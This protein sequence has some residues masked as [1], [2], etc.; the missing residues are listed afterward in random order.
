MPNLWTNSESEEAEVMV[1][2]DEKPEGKPKAGREVN[3]ARKLEKGRKKLPPAK[4][5]TVKRGFG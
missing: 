2:Q 3:G 4:S 5:Y 1:K